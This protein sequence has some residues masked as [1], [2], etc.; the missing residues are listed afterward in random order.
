A[1]APISPYLAVG[2]RA[3]PSAP[4]LPTLPNLIVSVMAGTSARRRASRFSLGMTNGEGGALTAQRLAY[5][6]GELALAIGLL[7]QQHALVEA[8]LA[9]DGVVGIPGRIEHLDAGA[10]LFRF[11]GKLTAVHAAGHHDVGE[12]Q[13]EVPAILQPVERR[14]AVG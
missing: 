14:R 13:V 4:S 6:L 2:G 11:I 1:P 8:A 9:H 7:Q 5:H 3:R 10:D 12:E